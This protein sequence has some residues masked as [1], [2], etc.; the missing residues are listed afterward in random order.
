M[1]ELLLNALGYLFAAV[2]AV[3]ITKR[4]G[5]GSVLGYLLAGV[6]IGPILGIV[7]S[8]ETH[9]LQHVAELGVVMMLF[10]IGLE[11]EP[12]KLWG[13]RTK[14]LGMGGLQV[15]LSI[16]AITGIAVLFNQPW[17]IGVAIGCI[18][19]LSSTA[20]VVQ[21]LGEKGLLS[22]SGGRSGFAVLLF[23]DIAAIPMLA[24]LPLLALPT[25]LHKHGVPV[26]VSAEDSINLLAGA[27]HTLKVTVTVLAMVAIVGGGHYLS[28]PLFRYIAA[29]RLRELFTLT[30]L[31][32]VIGVAVLM[33]LIGLSPALGAFLVGVVLANSDYRHELKNNIEPF[34]GILLGLF[35]ITVGAGMD[36]H[37]LWNN[38]GIIFALTLGMM[39]VKMIVLYLLSWV[40]RLDRR[41]RLLFTFSLAQAG[42][43]GFVLISLVTRERIVPHDVA[44]LLSLVVALSMLLTPLF[45]IVYDRLVKGIR[46]TKTARKQDEINEENPIIVLGQGRFGQIIVGMLA[47]CGYKMTV[48]DHDTEVVD[49]MSKYGIKTYFGDATRMDLLE[50]AGLARARLLIIAVGQPEQARLIA[51]QVRL[52]RADLP[53]VIRAYDRLD[54]YELYR[55]CAEH[56]EDPNA[57]IV[58]ETFDSAVRAGRLSLQALGIE[59]DKAVELANLYYHREREG[60]KM[61]AKYY[62]PSLPRWGN[63]ELLR[64]AKENDIET[65]RQMRQLMEGI[66]F[67]WKA[68]IEQEVFDWQEEFNDHINASTDSPEDEVEKDNLSPAASELRAKVEGSSASP[69]LEDIP[70]PGLDQGLEEHLQKDPNEEELVAQETIIA[71]QEATDTTVVEQPKIPQEEEKRR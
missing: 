30:A 63:A 64:V 39:L 70:E 67:E 4:L 33:S 45:F 32:L 22:T 40:F 58:R 2:V 28:R 17:Q 41:N 46:E 60:V 25:V 11:L 68:D 36:M 14:L 54:T 23:Q 48:I 8:S 71:T 7:G 27:S 6:A 44:N 61:M 55:A 18:L 26:K 51:K 57:D 3:S 34:K 65:R 47:A 43:F 69:T 12:A 21:T 20:I 29:S 5:L 35:F 50:T 53:M 37:L 42:E 9:E 66:D 19:S 16:A 49:R 52:M 1:T 38:I 10:L 59:H 62:D 31:T 15:L 13:L 24:M 56:G